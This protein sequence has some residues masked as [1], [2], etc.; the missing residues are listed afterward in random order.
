MLKL[1]EKSRKTSIFSRQK[2]MKAE[3]LSPEK[4]EVLLNNHG[5]IQLS[6]IPI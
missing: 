1:R 2:H 3:G 5:G 6:A 4:I